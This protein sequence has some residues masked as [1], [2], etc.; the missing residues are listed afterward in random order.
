MKCVI[1]KKKL[2]LEIYYDIYCAVT[3]ESS[4]LR[5]EFIM[6]DMAH[7]KKAVGEA[8][9]ANLEP[10]QKKVKEL[11]KNQDY[12]DDIIKTKERKRLYVGTKTLRKSHTRK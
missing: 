9:V 7:L 1:V 10:I 4:T 12:I 8:V 11:E 5:E 6:R 2:V 3:G